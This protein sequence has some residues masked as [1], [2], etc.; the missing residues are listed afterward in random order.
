MSEHVVTKKDLS[1]A[2]KD[3]RKA[4]QRRF[5]DYMRKGDT[6][7]AAMVVAASGEHEH[8]VRL[9]CGLPIEEDPLRDCDE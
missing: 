2:L 6:A 1:E 3:V 9:L 8:F 5:N 7:N 4:A